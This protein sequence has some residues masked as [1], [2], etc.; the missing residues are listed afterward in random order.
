[1][2]NTRVT[3][4]LVTVAGR[5]VEKCVLISKFTEAN[6]PAD[7]ITRDIVERRDV[8]ILSIYVHVDDTQII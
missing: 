5:K 7:T 8:M 4:D 2:T 3:V 6:I 1:M